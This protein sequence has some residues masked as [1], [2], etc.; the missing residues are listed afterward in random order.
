V[1]TNYFSVYFG[2]LTFTSVIYNI[3][4]STSQMTNSVSIIKSYH[5]DLFRERTGA[6]SENRHTTKW[7]LWQDS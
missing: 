7:T 1:T 3:K 4:F 5:L 2:R 6:C